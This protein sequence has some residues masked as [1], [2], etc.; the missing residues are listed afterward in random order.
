MRKKEITRQFKNFKIYKDLYGKTFKHDWV[1]KDVFL[2]QMLLTGGGRC[3][4][5]F[6]DIRLK[7]LTSPN[8]NMLVQLVLLTKFFKSELFLCLPKVDHVIKSCS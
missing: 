5:Y 1:A 8:F 6:R 4:S 2:I 3:N 7:I